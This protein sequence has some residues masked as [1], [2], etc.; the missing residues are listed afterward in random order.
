MDT[1]ATNKRIREI[2]SDIEQK[3]LIPNP[4]FQRRLVWSQKHKG[5]FIRTILDGLPFP[6]IYIA[7]GEVDVE[8]GRGYSMLVDG[9][10][11]VSTMFEFFKSSPNL[12]LPAEI[13][14]YSNLDDNQKL[15]FL[16]YKVVVRD[17][18]K[19]EREKIIDIFERINSTS[20]S[21]NAVEIANARYDNGFKDLAERITRLAFWEKNR[22]FRLNEVKRMQDLNFAMVL[23]GTLLTDYSNRDDRVEEFLIRYNDGF[24]KADALYIE[25][26]ST[27]AFVDDLCLPEGTRA[28][29]R[30][31]LFT[32]I[33][34]IHRALFKLKIAL[35]QR[36]LKLHLER[37]YE[38]VDQLKGELNSQV[39]IEFESDEFA[40]LV[41]KQQIRQYYRST[42]DATNDRGNRIQRGI[43][44]REIIKAGLRQ[45]D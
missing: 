1:T 28:W 4:D 13:L 22:V 17:L 20:Y 3:R 31:D 45:L 9:Q 36:V 24:D 44:L 7:A 40:G 18:G 21:L 29:Q 39:T 35:D 16:E 5:E 19:L 33:V 27:L 43:I 32:L 12:K 11:R 23:M 34:E 8:T 15:E 6:E 38:S 14:P 42:T 10:Q 2:I 26:E 25:V 41:S 37:F 30:A